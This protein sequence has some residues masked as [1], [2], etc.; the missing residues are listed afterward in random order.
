MNEPSP[1]ELLWC[2]R[3]LPKKWYLLGLDWTW[4]GLCRKQDFT[5]LLSVER[6]SFSFWKL[7]GQSLGYLS[8]QT[9]DIVWR[10]GNSLFAF[11]FHL[12]LG[13]PPPRLWPSSSWGCMLFPLESDF[14]AQ[15]L[16]CIQCFINVFW[17]NALY[18]A[19]RSPP[20]PSLLACISV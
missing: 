17:R 9:Q 10:K 15:C 13:L 2:Q 3:A 1:D 5:R 19:Q 12:D 7:P 14:W 16:A 4:S 18:I 6:F 11:S 8:V 20:A